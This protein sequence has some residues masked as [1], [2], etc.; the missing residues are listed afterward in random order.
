MRKSRSCGKTTSSKRS[1]ASSLRARSSA[2]LLLQ[3]RAELGGNA[4]AVLIGVVVEEEEE[5]E[6]EGRVG[7]REDGRQPPDEALA[8]QVR[9]GSVLQRGLEE[10]LA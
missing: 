1:V 2:P 9:S 4:A 8:E 3:V 6:E 5:E 10:R 7:R